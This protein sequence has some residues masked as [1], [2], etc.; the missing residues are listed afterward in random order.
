[1]RKIKERNRWEDDLLFVG[2]FSCA[3]I[4]ICFFLNFFSILFFRVFAW[5]RRNVKSLRNK[6]LKSFSHDVKFNKHRR[7]CNGSA[8]K[9]TTNNLIVTWKR[10]WRCN[11]ISFRAEWKIFQRKAQT[12]TQLRFKRPWGIESFPCYFSQERRLALPQASESIRILKKI[13]KI[14][15]EIYSL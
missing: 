12:E 2:F 4:F 7:F 3:L 14:L 13:S 6:S 10:E 5:K 9:L 11:R 15:H 8:G 1:M